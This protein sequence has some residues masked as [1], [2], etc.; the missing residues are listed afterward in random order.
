MKKTTKLALFVGLVLLTCA[1]MFTA[2]DSN[3]ETP[4]T[5]EPNDTKT[6]ETTSPTI[7][8]DNDGYVIV[9][10]VKTEY[11]IKNKNHNFSEWEL[12]NEFETDC[13]KKLFY[14]VCSDCS[15]I[16]W[17]DGKPEDHKF[18]TVTT[19]ATCISGGYD[20]KTCTVCN[21]I[22]I[23]N[24]TPVSS[25]NHSFGDW[26]ES[27]KVTCT[28]DGKDERVC[29]CGT[30][31]TRIVSALGDAHT[32][33]V[34]EAIAP[35]YTTRGKS[36]GS[37]CS[38]CN[39]IL[40][41]QRDIATIW[42]G[43]AIEPTVIVQIDGIYYYEINSAEELAYLTTAP[44]D[45]SGYNFVL[46]C[47]IWLNEE[48]LRFDENGELSNNTS[49]LNSWQ[50][51]SCNRFLGNGH[52][53]K[54]VYTTKGFIKT[55]YMVKDV[56]L[57]NAY[58]SGNGDSSRGGI[59]NG[60]DYVYYCSFD[61]VLYNFRY[62]GS[63][64]QHYIGGVVGC[65]SGSAYGCINYG[66]IVHNHARYNDPGI[67]GITG[68][69]W[70]GA[71]NDS[72]NYGNIIVLNPYS[73]SGDRVGGIVAYGR[74]RNCINYGDVKGV[75]IV[76][77][78]ACE[79]HNSKNYG[80][81]SGISYVYGIGKTAIGCTNY[82]AI[83]GTN[84][85]SGIGEDANG[86]SN[87]GTVSGKNY[88]GGINSTAG[89]ITNCKNLGNVSGTTNIGAIVGFF[90][91]FDEDSYISNCFYLKSNSINAEINGIGNL[92]DSAGVC[93]A[94]NEDFFEQE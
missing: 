54:G 5:N 77:G 74:A 92:E 66:L 23:C 69:G 51:F 52:S 89:K 42:S 27:I 57:V 46:K 1:L 79:S 59:C 70:Y 81:I 47:D 72:V 64:R 68:Y 65:L 50:G 34:D 33:V 73:G 48:E 4:T 24:E 17:K 43:D 60:A 21:K 35:T 83:S 41:E 61:G 15:T 75:D 45:W 85:I 49:H 36:E 91:I 32:P 88:V 9:N 12:Y 53:I 22:I 29:V 62:S 63:P 94:K 30:K 76:Y 84:Y 7:T 56:H 39:T 2:C 3:N 67:G 31:E 10:G 93:E 40:T 37:H 82:G 26:Y 55:C 11:E 25:T 16:E 18:Q 58:I 71:V 13:E 28:T 19:V 78:V 8:V 20:T 6:E 90:D 87:Y 14:R 86:S 80:S 44:A 38:L